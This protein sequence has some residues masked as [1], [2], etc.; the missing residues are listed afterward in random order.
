[1]STEP[2]YTLFPTNPTHGMIYEQ[3]NGVIYQYDASI[4][5]WLKIAS[6]NLVMSLATSTNN[7]AMSLDDF[8]KL[9]RLVIPPPTSSIIGNDCVTSYKRGAIALYGGDNFIS[10]DGHLDVQNLDQFG[11]NISESIPFQIHQHTYGFDFTLDAQQLI[12]ELEKRG[13]I[14]LTG[15]DGVKGDT[16]DTGD[17]GI[18]GILSGPPGDAGDNGFAPT[19]SL[20]IEPESVLAQ[21]KPGLKRALVNV[22]VVPDVVDARNYKLQFDRQ[23]VGNANGSASQFR[24]KQIESTWLL[25]IIALS[26]DNVDV[27]PLNCGI[28]GE[29]R[30][31]FYTL[32][33]VDIE[34]ILIAIQTKF[35][36]EVQRL[37]KG[38]EDIVAFWV[39]TMS[40]MFDEQKS[41]LCCALEKCI[42]GTKSTHARE[43]METVAALTLGKAKINLH[44]R[45]SRDSVEISSTR[46][47][48][49][50]GGPDLC[51]NGPDF[52]QNPAARRGAPSALSAAV[53]IESQKEVTPS[54]ITID[55]LVNSAISSSKQLELPRGD[56]V[57]TIKLATAQVNNM[58]RGNVKIRYISN[59]ERKVIQ[60]LDK[61][62]FTSLSEAQAAYEGL[63]VSFK[64]DGGNIEAFLPSIQPRQSSGQIQILITTNTDTAIEVIKP[65]NIVKTDKKRRP[66]KERK[67]KKEAVVIEQCHM[68][69][70]HLAWYETGWITGKCCGL[71]INISGQDYIIIKRSIGLEDNCGGGES[72]ETPC[73]AKFMNSSGHPAFAWPTFDGKTFAPIPPNGVAFQYDKSL[74][75]LVAAKIAKSEYNNGVGNPS[76]VRHLSYQLI[77]V[78]F[79]SA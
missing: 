25:A 44:G 23:V 2:T 36:D 16:G 49:E 47:L 64:H 77:T 27:D 11:D 53:E 7:G 65:K 37:K 15:L 41:A 59:G 14:R 6:D 60:F 34:P 62:S 51:Q 75:E 70:S 56:Y 46:L 4:R 38:Y 33:Y 21:P 43:H 76:G 18:N 48:H 63:S 52:P 57:A 54:L 12:L 32:Y 10:V 78:L 71:V 39:Q 79:P 42:S 24:V 61:G 35:A 19:C 67:N 13:Q 74:N 40:D 9:N 30:E 26:D 58:H 50:L 69:A 68:S 29:R 31:Q 17:A 22:R 66:K 8:K 55:P 1:M 45:N 28:P 72:L 3:K 5:A 20:S 73:I